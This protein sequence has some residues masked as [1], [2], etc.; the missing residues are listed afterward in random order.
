ML[1]CNVKSFDFKFILK[2]F[3]YTLG[4]VPLIGQFSRAVIYALGHA[5]NTASLK[6]AIGIHK[7]QLPT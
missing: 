5:L 1:L 7:S 3:C 2:R 4:Q 6:A